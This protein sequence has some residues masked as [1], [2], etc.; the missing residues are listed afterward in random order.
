VPE[1]LVGPM[2]FCCWET[3]CGWHLGANTCR[4]WHL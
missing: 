3:P 2:N 1:M 4:S